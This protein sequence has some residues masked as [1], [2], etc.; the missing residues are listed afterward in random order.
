[1]LMNANCNYKQEILPFLLTHQWLEFGCSDT[2]CKS[3]DKRVANKTLKL[4]RIQENDP[5]GFLFASL[6]TKCGQT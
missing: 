3:R 6:D 2:I 1:M 4:D 5:T